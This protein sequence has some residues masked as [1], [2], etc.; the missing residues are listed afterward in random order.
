[1][2]L[3]PF[4]ALFAASLVSTACGGPSKA[5]QFFLESVQKDLT[6]IKD[7]LKKGE[8][9]SLTC[10]AG[11][12]YGEKLKTAP[13]AEAEALVKELSALCDLDVPLAK[14]EKAVGEAEA[15]RKA[16]PD[17]GVLSE[18]FSADQKIAL[19]ALGKANHLEHE[20]VKAAVARWDA[21]CPKK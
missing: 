18:C 13:I 16:K 20:K 4:A 12:T 1:M 19:E 15:A 17:E 9:A 5:D 6:A 3:R 11:K 10:V 14:L 2:L 7:A 21:A 8:D